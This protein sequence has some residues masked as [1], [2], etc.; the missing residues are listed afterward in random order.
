MTSTK[1]ILGLDFGTTNSILANYEGSLVKP[2]IYEHPRLRKFGIPTVAQRLDEDEPGALD[3]LARLIGVHSENA[4]Y[5][6]KVGLNAWSGDRNTM[7]YQAARRFMKGLFHSYMRTNRLKSIESLVI[8]VPENWIGANQR[9]MEQGLRQRGGAALATIC[10][11]LK[12]PAPRIISEPVAATAYYA[13]R[14]VEEFKRPLDGY[15]IVYDHG[16]GTLDISLCRVQGA[17]VHRLGGVGEDLAQSRSGFGGV[18]YD[19]LVLDRLIEQKRSPRLKG[20]SKRDRG[21]WLLEFE[22]Q[23]IACQADLEQHLRH[24]SHQARADRVIF[25]VLEVD[26]TYGDLLEVFNEHFRKPILDLLHE[27]GR[28]AHQWTGEDI[29]SQP[30]RL[31]V[32]FAGGFTEFLPVQQAVSSFIV[33]KCRS[34]EVISA[35]FIDSERWQSIALGAALVAGGSV[36]VVQSFPFTFGYYYYRQSEPTPVTLVSEGTPLDTSS[37]DSSAHDPVWLGIKNIAKANE[38]VITFFVSQN[39]QP[40]TPLPMRKS[41]PQI[42]PHFGEAV[43]WRFGYRIRDGVL[44]I[45]I[46]SKFAE[47]NRSGKTVAV[48]MGNVF[49]L[50]NGEFRELELH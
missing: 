5:N 39:G 50:S 45:T 49:E 19:K 3:Q 42:L 21:I 6:F 48:Q 25:Q 16:G 23:K 33:D 40:P 12:L 35:L 31:H 18:M 7:A 2:S 32:A 37:S 43:A 27:M 44:A 20:M 8:T 10:K 9:A 34:T 41:L 29:W 47:P 11:E 13:F 15:V 38:N 28:R 26:V 14:H 46:T 22:A 17:M 30:E 36:S 24:P 4:D 1:Q